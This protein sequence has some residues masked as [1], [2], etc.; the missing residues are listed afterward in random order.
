MTIAIVSSGVAHAASIANTT[1]HWDTF[2]VTANTLDVT[3]SLSWSAQEDIIDS[4][5]WEV[6]DTT[7]I[8]TFHDVVPNPD[9]AASQ[10]TN[11]GGSSVDAETSISSTQISADATTQLNSEANAYVSRFGI[12]T[13][14]ASG[15]YT[16]SVD[17]SVAAEI[18]GLNTELGAPA[19]LEPTAFAFAELQFLNQN[20]GDFVFVFDDTA[21]VHNVFNSQA[22][23]GT[24]SITQLFNGSDINFTAGDQIE[25]TATVDSTSRSYS[26][27]VPL[28]PAIWMFASALGL[29]SFLRRAVIS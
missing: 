7:V 26:T 10:N 9:W 27:L 8:Q 24:L 25:I 23:S 11:D 13:A 4:T 22:S 18:N 28:P 3:N 21:L 2:A 12:F 19:G 16:F 17:Y 6:D 14:P 5:Y 15:T 1:I 20:S 29:L